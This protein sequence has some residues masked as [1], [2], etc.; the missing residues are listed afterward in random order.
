MLPGSGR[1]GEPA[2]PLAHPVIQEASFPV[3]ES[4]LEKEG[5]HKLPACSGLSGR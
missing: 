2:L 3:S 4:L 1:A 5:A